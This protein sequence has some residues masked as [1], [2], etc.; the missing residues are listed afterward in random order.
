MPHFSHARLRGSRSSSRSSSR[1]RSRSREGS[2]ESVYRMEPQQY[3][4]HGNYLSVPG[5]DMPRFPPFPPERSMEDDLSHIHLVHSKNPYAS[6]SSSGSEFGSSSSSSSSSSLVEDREGG[7]KTK[8]KNAAAKA[9]PR[10]EAKLG[11]VGPHSLNLH[12]AQ[13]RRAY[14]HKTKHRKEVTFGPHVRSLVYNCDNN[15]S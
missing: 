7:T 15:G 13:Q 9:M 1:S 8:F 12:T 6:D 11:T 10:K 5:A 4:Q 3:R 2:T 14:F